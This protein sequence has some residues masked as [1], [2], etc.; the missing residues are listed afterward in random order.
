MTALLGL[1]LVIAAIV[2]GWGIVRPDVLGIPVEALVAGSAVYMLL[3]VGAEWLRRRAP[4]RGFGVITAIILVDGLYLAWAMYVTGGTESPIKLLVYLHLVAV[5]LLASYRTGLKLA[6]WDSLL[7]IVVLYAQAAQLVPALDVTPGVAIEFEQAPILNVLAFWL[8]ALAT[9]VFSAMNE[10]E[11]RH[12]RADLQALVD[13][14]ARLDDVTDPVRQSQLAI[15]GLVDHFGFERGV[16]VGASEDRMVV[17]A[18]AGTDAPPTVASRP[19]SIVAQAWDKRRILAIRQLDPTGDPVLSG[20]LP[21]ARN[22]LVAPMMADGRAVGAVIVEHRSRTTR[23]IDRRTASVVSQLCAIAAL[24]LRN[25]V[26][27]RHVQDL[28]ERDALTGAAN[29]R[30]FQL[31]LE[32]VLDAERPG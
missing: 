30:M 25:A 23:G 19:D 13:I 31:S 29:R 5:S 8:F 18:S 6:L 21:D 10:R 22:L 7:L 11:L 32:R 1:R 9:S 4:R 24:N 14:G 2:V 27:L 28:A 17:L 20:L 26:L 12:R 3:A 15:D 16:V